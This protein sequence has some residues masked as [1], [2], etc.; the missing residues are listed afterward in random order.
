[1]AE[2][3]HT[4]KTVK[5]HN[6]NVECNFCHK[7]I[8]D[9][10]VQAMDKTWHQDH[11]VCTHCHKPISTQRFHVNNNQPY[12]EDDYSQLFLKRCAACKEPIKDV[13][14]M[15][16]G[17]PWHREHFTC[18]GCKA[19]LSHK[20]FFEND[21]QAYCQECYESKFCP[22]CKACKKP[23][24]ETAVIALSDKY[25]PDCFKCSRCNQPVMDCT[26]KM[27]NGKQVCASCET[28]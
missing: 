4:L 19:L 17:K 3:T 9:V 18:S 22:T 23:I 5:S 10:V 16:L 1:M 2:F 26:F 12:C 15:A 8:T 13:V 21:N 25:H 27:I 20:G 6:L 7:P 28:K 11:F 14:V 24:T